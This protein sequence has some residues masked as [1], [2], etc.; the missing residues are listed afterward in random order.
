MKV[1]I[2]VTQD[3]VDQVLAHVEARQQETTAWAASSSALVVFNSRLYSRVGEEVR[4]TMKAM[5][6]KIGHT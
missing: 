2:E 4:R 1:T 6:A 3:D 5:A